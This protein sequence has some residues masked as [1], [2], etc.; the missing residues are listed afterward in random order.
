M[1][2]ERGRL[3]MCR[4]GKELQFAV[5]LQLGLALVCV[6][7]M[8]VFV[9]S[10]WKKLPGNTSLAADLAI[11]KERPPLEWADEKAKAFQS[12]SLLSS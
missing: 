12:H 4:A 7:L 9:I 2:T 3:Q 8:L 11:L 1:L 10:M 6:C 5:G